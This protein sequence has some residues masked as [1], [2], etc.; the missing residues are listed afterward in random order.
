MFSVLEEDISTMKGIG[1]KNSCK[2]VDRQLGLSPY[3]QEKS[4]SEGVSSRNVVM[5]CPV[6]CC[7]W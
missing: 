3:L 5:F 1:A 4:P 2:L 6:P 7:H